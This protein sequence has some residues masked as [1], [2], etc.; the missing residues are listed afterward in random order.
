MRINLKNLVECFIKESFFKKLF[1]SYQNNIE[2][3]LTAIGVS[4]FEYELAGEVDE[5]RYKNY[6]NSHEFFKK[7]TI[8]DKVKWLREYFRVVN[9][10]VFESFLSTDVSF[11]TVKSSNKLMLEKIFLVTS[12]IKLYK[13]PVKATGII[14]ED[15]FKELK[16]A[17][18]EKTTDD[19]IHVVRSILRNSGINFIFYR[20]NPDLKIQGFVARHKD[21]IYLGVSDKGKYSDIL[22]F[23]LCH[24]LGHLVMGL[25]NF[26]YAIFDDEEQIAD[27][28]AEK[29]LIP[30]IEYKAFIDSQSFT[31]NRILEFSDAINV[32]PGIIVGRL[33]KDELIPK[34]SYNYLRKKA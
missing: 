13:D 12:N 17:T 21:E 20:Y 6:F 34:S 28:I 4:Q 25:L 11:R 3:A 33:Q 18:F 31:S 5:K 8:L 2:S 24:E 14:A 7:Q 30:E 29:I 10:D 23:T 26:D 27:S 15:L 1:S 22:W 32:A 9:L 19:T 16:E